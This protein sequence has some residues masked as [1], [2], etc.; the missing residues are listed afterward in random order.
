MAPRRSNIEAVARAIWARLYARHWPPGPKTGEDIERH[1]HV[2]AARLEAGLVDETGEN[3]G[4]FDF[5][6]GVAAYRDPRARHPDY[7]VPPLMPEPAVGSRPS[8]RAPLRHRH[9]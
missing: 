1:W 5:E 7:I 2:V 3:T 8:R 6:R 9:R 4:P